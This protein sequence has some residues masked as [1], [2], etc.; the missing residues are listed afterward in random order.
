MDRRTTL[1]LAGVA[2]ASVVTVAAVVLPK[3]PGLARDW[4]D[5]GVPERHA[6]LL[7]HPFPARLAPRGY[8]IAKIDPYRPEISGLYG[9]NV[10]FDGPDAEDSIGYS[11][12]AMNADDVYDYWKEAFVEY[13]EDTGRPSGY[14]LVDVVGARAFCATTEDVDSHGVICFA[15]FDGLAVSAESSN[16]GSRRGTFQNAVKLLRAGAAHW[17]S[18]R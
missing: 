4:L 6:L 1:V 11:V 12:Q 17:K 8:R 7:D 10:Y 3:L 13:P 14:R 15:A 5:G 16:S 9:V 2:A 18:I